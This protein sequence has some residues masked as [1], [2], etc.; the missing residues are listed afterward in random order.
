MHSLR[1]F[2]A[3]LLPLSMLGSTAGAQQWVQFANETSS[4]LVAHPSLVV[5]DNLEKVFAWADFDQ[6]GWVDLI[7]VRKFPGSMQGGFSN[8]LFMNEGGV[9]VDRTS[10]LGTCADI[11]GSLGLLDPTNDRRVHAID[12]DNDGWI[13]LVTATTMSDQVDWILGQPRVYMNRGVDANGNWRG[14]CFE[15]QRIP[16]MFS[17]T[18]AVANPRFCDLAFGDF[19]GDGFIDLFFTDYDTPET[20]GNVCIDLNGNG[21][22]DPGECQPSPPQIPA[23]DY[24]NRLVYNWGNDPNGPGPGHFYDTGTSKMSAAQ[25][26]SAFGNAAKA[27][28]LNGNGIPE[29]VRVNTLTGGQ[30]VGVL[31][32]QPGAQRGDVWAG[33]ANIYSGAPYNIEI[34]DLNGN[35]RLDIV[36]IDDGKDRYMINTGNSA[37]GQAQFVTYTINDSLSEFGNRTRIAD[38]DNDG[39]PEVLIADVD[40][41]LPPFC[42]STGRRMHIYRNTGIQTN[43]LV[44]PSPILPAAALQN[45]FDTATIDINNDGW[46]D[47]VIA[48]C[49]GVFVWMNVPPVSL[50]F[51]FPEG[52]PDSVAPGQGASFPVEISITGGGSV[53]AGSARL[54]SSNRNGPWSYTELVPEGAGRY[55]ATLPDTV[56]GDRLRFY[57]SAQLS[58]GGT[59]T[60]PAAA[61]FSVHE[62]T[63]STGID[64]SYDESFESGPAG[65]SVWNSPTMTLPGW[66]LATPNPTVS[67]G[68][69]VAPGS[70]PDGAFAW[71]TYNG[72]PTSISASTYDLDLGPTVL[73]SPAIPLGGSDATISYRRW[74]YCSTA[75][76][77][78]TRDSLLVLL[79]GDNGK[80]WLVAEEVFDSA[81]AW[82]EASL[83]V[84]DFMEPPASIIIRFSADDSPNNSLTEAGIDLVRIERLVCGEVARP[85]DINGDGRVD[86]AD[87]A[88]LLTAWGARGGPADLDGSGVVDGS[89]LGILLTNWGD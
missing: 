55:R 83:T 42:P 52:I 71:V 11:A 27:G 85:G 1:A 44:E 74:F 9:L 46:L 8:V 47:M 67:G 40:A 18:G 41:D 33:P 89:D 2:A 84:S 86:G 48:R 24:D 22:N 43:L 28:D 53:V 76:N 77:P 5:G 56:C 21:V 17:K 64:L 6:D 57:L 65:W 25:L 79:S 50:G 30:N 68:Q 3:T 60:S 38:L 13:D 78:K 72:P 16:Q 49:Q 4:R 51:S 63:V 80:T 7:M 59:T 75:S 87:L 54:Y 69:Q 62:A 82:V 10:Q 23:L 15:H 35:G 34:G 45:T 19:N 39:L 66:Q 81:S 14:F 70:A 32:T 88:L 12:V 73:T 36:V 58:N 61:P 29:I 31:S 37:S 26:A 20:S